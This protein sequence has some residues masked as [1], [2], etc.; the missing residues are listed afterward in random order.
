LTLINALFQ[1]W[2]RSYLLVL[3]WV[4][5]AL[6]RFH[7]F[8]K[9]W[10]FLNFGRRLWWRLLLPL[11]L[12]LTQSLVN[13]FFNIRWRNIW[14]IFWE[15]FGWWRLLFFFFTLLIFLRRD[16]LS[17]DFV[18]DRF[19]WILSV[20]WVFCF[21]KLWRLHASRFVRSQWSIRLCLLH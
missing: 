2:A 11:I 15:F 19:D 13:C 10:P 3:R 7:I 21:I 8:L 16:W 1:V 6:L 9:S 12:R 17:R 5:N 18:R 14:L 20:F 4:L